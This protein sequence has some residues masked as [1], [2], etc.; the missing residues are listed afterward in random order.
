MLDINFE[1]WFQC[2]LATD[3]DPT[4]EKRGVSGVAFALVGEPDLD[5]IIRF[6]QPRVPRLPGPK[7]GVWVK[8]VALNNQSV[9]DHTLVGAKVQL[10][11]KARFVEQNGI[12]APVDNAIIDP[13]YLQLSTQTGLILNRQAL[14]DP[15]KPKMSIYD[16]SP[17]L[18]LQRQPFLGP[19]SEKTLK[20][21]GIGDPQ[22]YWQTRIAELKKLKRRA[23]LP[24]VKAGLQ[25]RIQA[26]T[27]SED[28]W[29]HKRQMIV[30]KSCA[31]Y[32]FDLNGPIKMIDKQ[33]QLKGE[34]N[35]STNW[36]I[37]FWMGAWDN[38]ALCGYMQGT[39]SL[40]LIQ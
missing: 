36:P 4:D 26:L 20:S 12:V 6:H 5:R 8:S 27:L 33:N 15:Q 34:V 24:L 28:D 35:P 29:R 39:L 14:W 19:L 3:P 18:L 38:D 9:S 31:N 1:G 13:F 17:S 30:L 23:R 7:V 22:Q 2:R 25:Q 16:V 10:L 11:D 21:I 37:K 32:Q 40:P